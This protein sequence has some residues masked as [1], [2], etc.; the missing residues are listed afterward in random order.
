MAV[1]LQALAA[2][3]GHKH[4]M[5]LRTQREGRA[6]SRSPCLRPNSEKH[7]NSPCTPQLVIKKVQGGRWEDKMDFMSKG[8]VDGCVGFSLYSGSFSTGVRS[9]SLTPLSS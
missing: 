1:T 5:E 6:A 2:G 9:G 7:Q 4:K 8:W 3:N